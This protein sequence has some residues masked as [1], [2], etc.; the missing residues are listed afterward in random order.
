MHIRHVQVMGPG[1]REIASSDFGG[2]HGRYE[3]QCCQPQWRTEQISRDHLAR[4][5]VQVEYGAE[6]T[7]IEDDSGTLRVTLKVGGQTSVINPRYILG[8]DGAHSVTRHSMREH[9]VGETYG[10]QYVV[11]DVRA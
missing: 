6:V 1:M 8:A 9:L 11:A 2:L 7:S 10:G 4:A 5:G 3:F